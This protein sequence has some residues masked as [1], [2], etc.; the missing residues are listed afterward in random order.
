MNISESLEKVRQLKMDMSDT[1]YSAFVL[2]R[3]EAVEAVKA[4]DVVTHTLEALMEK[5][6]D[7]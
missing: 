5:Q 4:L 6:F 1:N 2:G 3:L 7:K